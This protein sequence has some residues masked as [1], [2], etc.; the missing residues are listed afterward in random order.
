MLP[1]AQVLFSR[2]VGGWD[3]RRWRPWRG[4]PAERCATGDV[5]GHRTYYRTIDTK[6]EVR[7]EAQPLMRNRLAAFLQL[8][9]RGAD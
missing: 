5:P 7:V 1:G 2:P 6:Y 8:T 3:G 4:D 9:G